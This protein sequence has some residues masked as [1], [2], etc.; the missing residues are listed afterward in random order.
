MPKQKAD[1]SKLVPGDIISFPYQPT[2][3]KSKPV[4]THTILV[5]NPK[6]PKV[7]KGGGTEFYVNGLKLE[8]SNISIFTNKEEAWQLL[9]RIGQIQIVSAKDEIY[10]VQV[11]PKFLG[12]FGAKEKLYK[13][14]RMT[15][16]GKKAEYRTYVWKQAKKKAC[17]YEPIKLPSEKVQMLLDSQGVGGDIIS[18]TSL[19]GRTEKKKI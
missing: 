13:E 11:N 4:R 19:L 6:Y 18:R 7:L 15:P 12:G 17:F 16:V 9:E 5:L 3:D 8:G 14:I 10:R 1:R 2:K